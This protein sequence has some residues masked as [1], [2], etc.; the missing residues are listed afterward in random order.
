MLCKYNCIMRKVIIL[1]MIMMFAEILCG[2]SYSHKQSY[3]E[4]LAAVQYGNMWGFVDENNKL[5]IT[6]AFEDVKPFKN[7][8]AQV[9]YQGKWIYI[10]KKGKITSAPQIA[11]NT[12]KPSGSSSKSGQSSSGSKN[13]SSSSNKSSSSSNYYKSSSSS[14][15]NNNSSS[16]RGNLSISNNNQT[17]ATKLVTGRVFDYQSKKPIASAL[18]KIET[19][20]RKTYRA[21]TNDNGQFTMNNNISPG[22]L[23]VTVVK[24]YYYTSRVVFEYNGYNSFGDIGLTRNYDYQPITYSKVFGRA[25][26]PFNEGVPYMKIKF[27]A[28]S[29]EEEFEEKEFSTITDANGYYSIRLPKGSDIS[30]FITGKNDNYYMWPK[31]DWK[32]SHNEERLDLSFYVMIGSDVDKN[33]R[34]SYNSNTSSE[35]SAIGAVIAG[36]IILGGAVAIFDALNSSSSKSSSSSSLDPCW[37]NDIPGSDKVWLSEADFEQSSDYID[38]KSR[39]AVTLKFHNDNNW[40]MKVTYQVVYKN[41]KSSDKP[42]LRWIG[43]EKD[44]RSTTE[45][46]V[47]Q[48]GKVIEC[49]KLRKIE[50]AR[51]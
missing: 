34:S 7:G 33:L 11:Q 24:E 1:V 6:Y 51:Y 20:D 2:Q 41:E 37:S 26:N 29:V 32:A 47:G 5:V 45:T 48:P 16:N 21:Y 30:Y 14:S 15:L 18:V 19:K 28:T 44:D 38:G 12:N 22:T 43:L 46:I 25:T 49:I 3:S 36:A 35:G 23:D 13:S 8:V 9:K 4:G 17:N 50:P 40:P 10:D 27:L 39:T 31:Y 42:D